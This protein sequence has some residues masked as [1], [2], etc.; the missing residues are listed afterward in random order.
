MAITLSRLHRASR[1]SFFLFV[2]RVWEEKEEWIVVFLKREAMERRLTRFI[3]SVRSL[4]SSSG[5]GGSGRLGAPAPIDD[6][7][8]C[9]K[10]T[11]VR[12]VESFRN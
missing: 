6:P 9:R 8:N 4:A 12:S 3:I 10:V 7:I 5:V 11:I 2:L 1:G